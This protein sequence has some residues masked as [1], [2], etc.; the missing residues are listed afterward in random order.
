MTMNAVSPVKKHTTCRICGGANLTQY[1]DLGDQPP[2]NSFIR[3]EEL[4][5]E[6]SF[7]LQIFLCHDCGLSQLLHVVPA[8]D[9]FDDYAYLSSK[10]KALCN[11]YQHLVDFVL[12]RFAPPDEA[13]VV[14]I[15]CNDGIML[16]RYPQNHFRLL[17]VEPSSAGEYAKQSGHTVIPEFFD[18]KLGALI[19][20]EH[21]HASIITATNVFAHVDDIHSFTCGVTRLLASDGIF[22]IEFPY[23]DDMLEHVYF[24]TIYHEHLC[25]FALT[26]L[27][28]LFAKTGLRAFDAIRIDGGAS[29]PAVRL[30]VCLK[31][32]DF[33]TAPVINE[34]L[35]DELSWGVTRLDR[36][37]KFAAAA[38][39]LKLRLLAMIRDLKQSGHRVGAYGAPAK[40]NTLLNFLGLS[41]SEIEAI[42]EN[43]ELKIGKLTPGSHIPIISDEEFMQ[44]DITHA[45]LLTWN[46]AS[47]FLKNSP[48]VGKGGKFIIPL[49]ELCIRP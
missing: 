32:A 43:N 45:L 46:Y 25:Y 14:D 17:G 13:L 20:D 33:K 22:V 29:G 24:D 44:S 47:F 21:G 42:A 27:V 34:L 10:S 8:S 9:I 12:D 41:P 4:D 48:F 15:G 37:N 31:D 1:L 7:P 6:Q 40:G 23:L 2:S 3:P 5:Q 19:A 28:H 11:H 26:P 16:N 49:P 18:E 38:D 30:F 35:E 36:Y 39:D